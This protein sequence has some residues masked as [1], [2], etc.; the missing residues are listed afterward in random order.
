[1]VKFNAL[2]REA[3]RDAVIKHPEMSYDA[4]GEQFSCCR[5]T[6]IAIAK[7]GGIKRKRGAGAPSFRHAIARSVS[8]PVSNE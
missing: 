3:I 7:Q 1:M 8:E 4:I 6:V 2:I 5:L